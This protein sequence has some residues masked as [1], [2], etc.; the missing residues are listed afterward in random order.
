MMPIL[1]TPRVEPNSLKLNLN[2]AST[3]VRTVY[4]NLD[5]INQLANKIIYFFFAITKIKY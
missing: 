1:N 5:R 4:K 2:L 3:K